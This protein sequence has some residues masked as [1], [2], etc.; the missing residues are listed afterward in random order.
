MENT[1]IAQKIKELTLK[2]IEF[3]QK[4]RG[5]V[6]NLQNL[7]QPISDHNKECVEF[8]NH[9]LGDSQEILIIM[10]NGVNYKVTRPIREVATQEAYLPYGI[11]FE[12]CK[13]FKTELINQ[14]P[15]L[16]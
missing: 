4:W 13:V 9:N 10:D 11:D 12:E 5:A 7:V 2:E 3:R 8:W 15:S 1:N 16:I 14:T 6:K